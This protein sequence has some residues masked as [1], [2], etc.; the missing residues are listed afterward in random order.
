MA[1]L[2]TTH[3]ERLRSVLFSR[4]KLADFAAKLLRIEDEAFGP[5]GRGAQRTER[6]GRLPKDGVLA[7]IEDLSVPPTRGGSPT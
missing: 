5:D 3:C 1:A 7:L 6:V 4:P 2:A